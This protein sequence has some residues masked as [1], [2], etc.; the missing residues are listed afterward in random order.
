MGVKKDALILVV[1]NP[2]AHDLKHSEAGSFCPRK[3]IPKG[4]DMG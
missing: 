3:R 1:K 4:M 2:Y